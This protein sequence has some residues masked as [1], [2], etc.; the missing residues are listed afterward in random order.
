LTSGLRKPIVRWSGGDELQL[1]GEGFE[2]AGVYSTA[3]RYIAERRKLGLFNQ[4]TARNNWYALSSFADV[5]GANLSIGRVTQRH[6]E[7]WL[8]TRSDRLAPR[9]VRV[10]LSMVRT[11]CRW[12][13][14]HDLMRRDPTRGIESP[15]IARLQPRV[16]GHGSVNE[17][18]LHADDR[19]RV[20]VL[21]AVQEGLRC[22]E[23][24]HLTTDMVDHDARLAFVRGK[25][26]HERYV[27]ISDETRKAIDRYLTA[28]PASPGTPLVRSYIHPARGLTPQTVSK[29]VS[30][31]MRE[32]GVK[33]Q[34]RDGRSAHA[35][36]H[37]CAS[38]MLDNGADLRDVQEMLGHQHLAT[39]GIYLR[40]QVALTRLRDAASGRDYGS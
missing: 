33:A 32:A 12:C 39:T 8:L 3:A 22:A 2:L 7:K 1:E 40:R 16:M 5:T 27:P 24:A 28:C 35:L 29:L 36:R 37:T 9:S 30:Q 20:I 10:E 23:I 38:D 34:P 4:K 26:G 15:R 14:E 17:V 31:L 6:V 13:V 18:L 19:G 25:G 11:F 21:L